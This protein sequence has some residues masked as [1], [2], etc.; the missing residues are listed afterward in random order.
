MDV[1]RLWWSGGSGEGGSG[2]ARKSK[3]SYTLISDRKWAVGVRRW[4]AGGGSSGA[5]GLAS[6]NAGW[7]E[8]RGRWVL[9]VSTM[10]AGAVARRTVVA[11]LGAAPVSVVA[12]LTSGGSSWILM[13]ADLPSRQIDLLD[14]SIL[15]RQTSPRT[16]HSTYSTDCR[17]VSLPVH[18]ATIPGAQIVRARDS[19]CGKSF[20]HTH[21]ETTTLS[22]NSWQLNG[23]RVV[24]FKTAASG[25]VTDD[26]RFR[27]P[28]SYTVK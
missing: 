5:G 10:G 15:Q 28:V 11:E 16:V 23:G 19:V 2:I 8:R 1:R 7:W 18:R 12:S 27:P 9:E 4:G 21:A 13:M 26:R 20:S 17:R 22:E 25:P 24:M 6:S 3:Q 14:R